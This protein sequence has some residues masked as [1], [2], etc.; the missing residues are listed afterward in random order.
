[1]PKQKQVLLN[2]EVHAMFLLFIVSQ[3]NTVLDRMGV[4]PLLGMWGDL[5]HV[6]VKKQVEGLCDEK[7]KA[8]KKGLLAKENSV[9]CVN[10]HSSKQLDEPSPYLLT[11]MEPSTCDSLLKHVDYCQKIKYALGVTGV[12]EKLEAVEGYGFVYEGL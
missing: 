2:P 8:Q 6:A 12:S 4:Y 9:V 5:D 10:P 3:N 7:A 1:M 11:N